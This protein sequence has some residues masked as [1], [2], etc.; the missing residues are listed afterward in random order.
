MMVGVVELSSLG[1]VEGGRFW[2]LCW[3]I[4]TGFAL[5]PSSMQDEKNLRG[6]HVFWETKE[7]QSKGIGPKIWRLWLLKISL[8]N[9][10]RKTDRI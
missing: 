6:E 8:S 3:K 1:S 5:L 7:A 4:L 2:W 10:N 9:E